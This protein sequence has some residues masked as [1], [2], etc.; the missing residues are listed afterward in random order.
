MHSKFFITWILSIALTA[1]M[2][3]SITTFLPKFFQW[4]DAEDDNSAPIDNAGNSLVEES[5]K[6]QPYK[7]AVKFFEE[8]K[9]AEALAIFETL[10][11]YKD[12]ENYYSYCQNIIE[13]EKAAAEKEAKYAGA[14]ALLDEEKYKEAIAAFTEL[15]DYKESQS[16]INEIFTSLEASAEALTLG[17]KY[18][19]A[20]AVLTELGYNS[21]NNA[22]YQ[23]YDFAAKGNFTDAV[24]CGLSIVVFPDGTE[25]IPNNCFKVTTT[26]NNLQKVV[27]PSSVKTIGDFAFYGCAK[28]TEI[29]LHEGLISIGESAF[30]GCMGL[31]SVT[32]PNSLLLIGKSAFASS[33]VS[34]ISFPNTLQTIGD[35]A[36]ANCD[37]ITSIS[38]PNSLSSIGKSAFNG[39]SGLLSVTIGSGLDTVSEN[40]FRDCERLV[41]VTIANGVTT[42]D[43]YAFR[44]CEML[45][46]ISLPATLE[47]IQDNAFYQCKMLAE[48]TVPANVTKIGYNVF[49]GCSAL[50]K[51]YFENTEGWTD[52]FRSLNVLDAETNASKLVSSVNK[53]WSRTT[54]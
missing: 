43:T 15:G 3:F 26:S 46:T 10:E 47:K 14:L 51:I 48:I 21:S 44:G 38:L 24:A 9:Y 23:A 31:K 5:P 17:G 8:G 40:A 4:D 39:C 41:S 13:A 12:S 6:E 30:D 35:E 25:I 22:M 49:S 34:D 2:L 16:K 54:S 1:V 33:G 20:C 7:E 53:S 42:I 32:L 11:N 18:Q 28:L 36:F 19:E 52:G 27:L 45:T 37:F 50:K 29:E